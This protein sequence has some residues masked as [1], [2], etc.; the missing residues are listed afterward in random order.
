[1]NERE[2]IVEYLKTN[3]IKYT[4]H[5]HVY[6]RYTDA[7]YLIAFPKPEIVNAL[8]KIKSVNVVTDSKT[9]YLYKNVD[10]IEYEMFTEGL[11]IGVYYRIKIYNDNRCYDATDIIACYIRFFEP[12]D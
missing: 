5:S 10:H 12:F 11:R 3:N 7:F 9:Y 1:M 6:T 2:E 4:F 8:L